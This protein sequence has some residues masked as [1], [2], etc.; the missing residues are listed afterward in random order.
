[1]PTFCLIDKKSAFFRGFFVF[2][3]VSKMIGSGRLLEPAE[4]LHALEDVVS[5]GDVE[6]RFVLEVTHF[7]GT[8]VE[9]G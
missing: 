9:R 6:V 5:D 8:G 3:S 2:F 4:A 7:F 1:M